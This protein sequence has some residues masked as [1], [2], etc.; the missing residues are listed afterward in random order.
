MIAIQELSNPSQAERDAILLPLD[1][2]SAQRGFHW[3][4]D[5]LTIALI[6][7]DGIKGG[8]LGE[9]H[10]GWFFVHILSVQ[11]E[12]RGQ[13]HGQTLMKTAEQRAQDHGCCG[14]WLDTFTFQA[15]K[16]YEKLGYRE[17]GRLPNYPEGQCRIFYQKQF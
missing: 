7:D 16:F 6:D 3:K 14:V 4:K 13:G 5:L 15:P 10:W 17:F 9:I 12:L 1:D 2:Y 8:L 11:E